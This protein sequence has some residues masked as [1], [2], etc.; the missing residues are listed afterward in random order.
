MNNNIKNII[1]NLDRYSDF[2]L[3]ENPVQFDILFKDR[4]FDVV[5]VHSTSLVDENNIVGFC[6][7]FEWNNNTIISLD[8]DS[9]NKFMNVIGYEEFTNKEENIQTGIDILVENW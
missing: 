7:V 9:Y 2:I 3:L 1:K 5:Q 4:K 8:G 6:G